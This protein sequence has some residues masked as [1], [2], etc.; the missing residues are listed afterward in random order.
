MTHRL[1][2]IALVLLTMLAAVIASLPAAWVG[3][4]LE[5]QT[6]ARLALGDPQGSVWRGSAFIG[7]AGGDDEPL[8]PL[9][10]G[11][12]HWRLSPLALAGIVDATLENPRALEAPLTISG[13]WRRWAVG[14]GSITLPAER[15]AALGAPLNTLQP[16]GQMRLSWTRLVLA[17]AE[18][19]RGVQVDGQM[20]LDLTQMASALSPVKPLGAYRMRFDWQGSAARVDLKSLSG[21]LLLAGQG[22]FADGRLQ[23]S[24]QA[25]AAEGEE[26]RLAILLNLLGQRRQVG[27]RTVI[28]LDFQ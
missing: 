17:R 2:W 15:L 20:Q 19:G 8:V 18:A 21:P 27:N 16:S 26:Q 13:S 10:P 5:Q 14:D 1:W 4:L 7:A 24:G 12:F 23:F 11:R 22:R 25:W 28:A 6:G 3:P 9:L